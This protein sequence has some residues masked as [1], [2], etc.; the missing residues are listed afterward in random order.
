[1]NER[2]TPERLAT[3]R[4]VLAGALR[5]RDLF[6]SE[7]TGT[8]QT[9][10]DLVTE[11]DA[12]TAE[13]EQHERMAKFVGAVAEMFSR[14]KPMHHESKALIQ[15]FTSA[16]AEYAVGK[17]PT[18]IR[19]AEEFASDV[20]GKA[21]AREAKAEERGRAAEFA[22]IRNVIEPFVRVCASLG[23]I[24][25]GTADRLLLVLGPGPTLDIKEE[26]PKEMP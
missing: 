15:S 13:T 24:P 1:M 17:L 5:T 22:A 18:P 7:L 8:Q 25:G 19:A 4:S 3:I 10:L 20:L 23:S 2:P 9:V 16:L 12:L 21:K 6:E 11:I 14:M 26:P